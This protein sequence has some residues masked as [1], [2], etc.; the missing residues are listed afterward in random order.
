MPWGFAWFDMVLTCC[1]AHSLPW[2]HVVFSMVAGCSLVSLNGGL[3]C[4]FIWTFFKQFACYF[5]NNN[6]KSLKP[7]SNICFLLQMAIIKTFRKI[8]TYCKTL[9]NKGLNGPRSY[10]HQAPHSA[11][12]QYYITSTYK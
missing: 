2:F 7:Y 9:R 4:E 3:Q 12:Q 11:M 1:P 8:Y 10:Q 5:D 6:S